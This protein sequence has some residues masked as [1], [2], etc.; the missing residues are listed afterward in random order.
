MTPILA[1]V[2]NSV[3]QSSYSSSAHKNSW[4]ANIGYSKQDL[5]P[6]T[7]SS[8]QQ[9]PMALFERQ[10]VQTAL[11][12]MISVVTFLRYLT[13]SAS[14]GSNATIPGSSIPK[15]IQI[16]VMTSLTTCFCKTVDLFRLLM[17]TSITGVVSTGGVGLIGGMN[18]IV[19]EQ[20]ITKKILMD[21]LMNDLHSIADNSINTFYN[22]LL[23]F[24]DKTKNDF[25]SNNAGLKLVLQQADVMP[26]ESFSKLVGQWIREK[27]NVKL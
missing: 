9:D 19:T 11:T 14:S 6:P 2:P 24:D 8:Y 18:A 12:A 5:L 15:D 7:S 26:T 20:D 23:A 25:V 16:P 13:S 27:M 4:F 21:G 17:S 10:K 1:I 3:I 22:M